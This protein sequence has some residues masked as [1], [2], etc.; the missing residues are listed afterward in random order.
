MSFVPSHKDAVVNFLPA[1]APMMPKLSTSSLLSGI[2][3][4]GSPLFNVDSLPLLLPNESYAYALTI[5]RSNNS[6]TALPPTAN[7]PTASSRCLGTPSVLWRLQMGEHGTAHGEDVFLPTPATALG[8]ADGPFLRLQC[9]QSPSKVIVGD[10]FV[11]SL[12]ITNLTNKA[13]SVKLLY[14]DTLPLSSSTQPASTSLNS[15]VPGTRPA[16]VSTSSQ[17]GGSSLLNALSASLPSE[18][19]QTLAAS[20]SALMSAV[21]G[22]MNTVSNDPTTHGRQSAIHNASSNH[23]VMGFHSGGLCVT[24]L[25]S[26]FVS[27]LG[28]GESVDTTITVCALLGGLQ[29]LRHIN[30]V[31]TLTGREYPGGLL[32]KTFVYEQR[33]SYSIEKLKESELASLAESNDPLLLQQDFADMGIES[34]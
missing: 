2:D 23:R 15:T 17:H 27:I 4:P 5:T 22:S 20:S 7:T 8:L 3:L 9:I 21:N 14:R 16:S 11:V 31:D 28:V 32:F 34:V 24:G 1:P 25:S 6:E 33:S 13:A 10:D 30:I 18:D 19:S 12:R 29:E 26:F